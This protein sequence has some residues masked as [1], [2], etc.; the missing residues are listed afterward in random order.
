MNNKLTSIAFSI[1]SNK[2]VYALL[3]GSGISRTSGIPT[4]WGIVIDLIKQLA[5]VNSESCTPTPEEWFRSKYGDEPDYSTI[6]SKLAGTPTERV[7]LLKPYFEQKND[8]EQ[9]LKLPTPAHK[10]IAKLVK[11][12]YIKV[13]ITTNFDRLIEQALQDE[14]IQPIVVKQPDD[15]AGA[16]PLVHSSFT[17]IKINGDYLDSRFLNTKEELAG[18]PQILNDYITRVINEYGLISCGWSAKWDEGLVT[19]I[20]KSEN[21]RFS[22]YW[23]YVGHCEPELKDLA[24]FRKGSPLE[25]KDADTFFTEINQK[26]EALEN[27]NNNHPI[28]ADIAVA[29]LKKYIVRE[30]GR[31]LL[32]DLLHS[33][34]ES[35][36]KRIQK[37]ANNSHQT[38]PEDILP[39]IHHYENNL[40]ILIPLLIHGTIWAKPEHEDFLLN[41]IKRFGSQTYDPNNSFNSTIKAFH[42]YP[43]LLLIYALGI[44][45]VHKKNYS[46]LTK[47]FQLK[48]PQ[49]SSDETNYIHLIERFHPQM[50]LSKDFN[51]IINQKYKTPI[52][53]Y[54]N[55]KL[56]PY[57]ESVIFNK[58]N[59]EETI[60]LFEY[61]ISINYLH[62][63]SDS[64]GGYGFP[65][66]QYI[67]RHQHHCKRRDY[68]P[69]QFLS[70]S[71]VE[72]ETWAPLKYGMF[73]GSF[74]TF[75]NLRNQIDEII[76]E[77]SKSSEF[78]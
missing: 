3:L 43:V 51:L 49:D 1:Y 15:I 29:R 44:T 9:G 24:A 34:Q 70:L 39:F 52:S 21:Y 48:I 53:T 57:F 20:R 10:A 54:T 12:G 74:Y 28:T 31:I 55:Y 50:I 16:L 45:A 37:A 7:G 41:I 32:H 14:G 61:L 23:T 73:D 36:L 35:A 33:E 69:S 71:E 67:W 47:L 65:L 42:Y 56:S 27:I 72:K 17:L 25:I 38:T 30:D 68:L 62:L 4:G 46:L 26:I 13:I 19:S 75:K 5:I 66:G 78:R 11:G 58:T 18:Y 60:D 6:L 64:C 2:G 59:Y 76:S 63:A 40:E 8:S 77:A 22:S